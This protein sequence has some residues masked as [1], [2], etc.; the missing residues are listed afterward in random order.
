MK[1]KN[2]LK[3]NFLFTVI[4]LFL[5]V[6]CRNED[7]NKNTT[8]SLKLT[9]EC[10]SAKKEKKLKHQELPFFKGEKIWIKKLNF[11]KDTFYDGGMNCNKLITDF[12]G[13]IYMQIQINYGIL[14]LDSHRKYNSNKTNLIF[15]KFDNKGNLI[16]SYGLNGIPLKMVN[17]N[18]NTYFFVA[19]ERGKNIS[20]I[21]Y[22][23]SNN[24]EFMKIHQFNFSDS[25]DIRDVDVD[26]TGNILF[27]GCENI[28]IKEETIY[29]DDVISS[30]YTRKNSSPLL[31]K[32]NSNG[33]IVWKK[34]CNKKC[35]G[36]FDKIFIDSKN[37]IIV[38][39][40]FS[41]CE[42]LSTNNLLPINLEG[43]CFIKFDLSGKLLLKKIINEYLGVNLEGDGIY[44][45][46]NVSLSKQNH[47]LLYAN[48]AYTH[49]GLFYCKIYNDDFNLLSKFLIQNI[50]NVELNNFVI[51]QK[52]QTIIAS[53]NSE[54]FYLNDRETV[55]EFYK[56]QKL[57][58]RRVDASG[59]T[60]WGKTIKEA[61]QI[62]YFTECNDSTFYMIASKINNLGN[63]YHDDPDFYDYYI[64][65]YR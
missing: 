15:V 33:I 12:K 7:K 31:I 53:N 18:G 63:S 22:V 36:V 19:K 58:F 35:L 44:L 43:Q 8:D 37:N 52:H 56:R 45:E 60:I 6:S 38:D 62:N 9:K 32:Y 49:K 57:Y 55:K 65:A 28:E 2:V 54:F 16:N 3:N 21:D 46:N 39:G 40:D 25:T 24:N 26:S 29:G 30:R 11:I 48:E 34:Y 51:E 41:K 13:N 64:I 61:L 23:I 20:I 59:H 1:Q 10:I 42:I 17:R 27:S 14:I 4:L 47:I 50:K 5:L